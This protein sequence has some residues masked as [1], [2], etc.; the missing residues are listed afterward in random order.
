MAP[1]WPCA[2]ITC[3]THSP[4]NACKAR[5][6]SPIGCLAP[7]AGP[8]RPAHT[9]PSILVNDCRHLD[10]L[11]EAQQQELAEWTMDLRCSRM[12]TPKAPKLALSNESKMP[13]V[14]L[15]TW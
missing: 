10:I 3:E 9:M 5:W 2:S 7:E 15:G 12:A 8:P 4:L 6:A 13:V 1:L 14:G 11:S